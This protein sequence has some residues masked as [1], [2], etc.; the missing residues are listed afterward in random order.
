MQEQNINDFSRDGDDFIK[1]LLADSCSHKRCAGLVYLDAKYRTKVLNRIR[2]RSNNGNWHLSGADISEIWEATMASIQWQVEEGR[3]RQTGKLEAYVWVIAERRAFDF[4][5]RRLWINHDVDV[6]N[7][8]IARYDEPHETPAANY[9][10]KIRANFRK[11][12]KTEKLVFKCFAR[13]FL[14]TGRKPPPAKVMTSIN[15]NGKH[16]LTHDAVKSALA[17]AF[18]KLRGN[19]E[20]K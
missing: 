16:S 10:K 3:F 12:S 7:I 11:L 6:Q 9:K 18:R 4:L 2:H 13:Q 14:A 1:K 17:R 15:E 8:E 19:G 20:H 5:R